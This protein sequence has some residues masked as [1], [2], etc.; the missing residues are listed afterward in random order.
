MRGRIIRRSPNYGAYPLRDLPG[1]KASL[2]R[3]TEVGLLTRE[4][5][6]GRTEYRVGANAVR[7]IEAAAAKRTLLFARIEDQETAKMA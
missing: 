6:R 2:A 5:P 4:Q 1:C 3:L 7:M